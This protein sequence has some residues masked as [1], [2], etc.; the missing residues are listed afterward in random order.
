M[1][2]ELNKPYHNP[3]YGVINAWH[4]QS[5]F[6]FGFFYFF[7][8]ATIAFSIASSTALKIRSVESWRFL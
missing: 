8:A 1:L 7:A 4:F 2:I 6:L 3:C 5:S